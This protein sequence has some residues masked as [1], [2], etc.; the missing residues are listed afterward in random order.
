MKAHDLRRAL[1]PASAGA[2]RTA[3][4]DAAAFPGSRPSTTERSDPGL[5]LRRLQAAAAGS[6]RAPRG[7]A[8]MSAFVSP[9]TFGFLRELVPGARRRRAVVEH[10]T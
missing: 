2:V 9:R 6:P 3:E 10:P 8:P 1:A 5:A 4:E 7:A